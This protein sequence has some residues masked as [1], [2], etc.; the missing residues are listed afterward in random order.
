METTTFYAMFAV[1]IET[2]APFKVVWRRMGND[3]R[4][5]IASSIKDDYL[6]EKLVIPSDTVSFIP[7]HDEKE[8]YFVLGL[9]NSTPAR[10][11]I[12]SFSPA[13]RGLGAPSIMQN[14]KIGR[15]QAATAEQCNNISGLA[16]K[17]SSQMN[18]L[19]PNFAVIDGALKELDSLAAEYWKIPSA[20]L[21]SLAESVKK[22]EHRGS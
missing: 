14:L 19:T 2:Y 5:A 15:Y 12:Y 4:A 8:A 3:F 7:F 20:Q 13:G 6:G 21:L 9:I 17:I 10:A 1:G 18:S 11:A 16:K 22:K